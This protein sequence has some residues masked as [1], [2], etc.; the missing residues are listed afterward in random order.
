MLSRQDYLT[1]ARTPRLYGHDSASKK[2]G[3][4]T[5]ESSLFISRA[6]PHVAAQITRPGSKLAVNL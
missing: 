6:Y 5:S 2:E 3:K 4:N 1:R